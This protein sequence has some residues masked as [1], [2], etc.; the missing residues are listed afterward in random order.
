MI[1]AG[2]RNRVDQCSIEVGEVFLS[3][4]LSW[5][6]AVAPTSR[7]WKHRGQEQFAE[8]DGGQEKD[9][10]TAK[11]GGRGCKSSEGRPHLY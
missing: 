7:M 10:W 9:R 2:W 3:F 6:S 11:G 1:A 8:V 4:G 5:R